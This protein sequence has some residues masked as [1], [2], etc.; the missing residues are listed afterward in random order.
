LGHQQRLNFR[1]PA[2]S[3]AGAWRRAEAMYWRLSETVTACLVADRILLLDVDRDRYLTVPR[4]LDRDFLTWLEFGTDRPETCSEILAGIGIGASDAIP[5][6]C[7]VEKPSTLD[8]RRLEAPRLTAGDLLSVGRTVMSAAREVRS[9]PFREVL[10]KRAA[11]IPRHRSATAEL[12]SRLARF[13]AART[14]IPV[15]RVCL[16]DC[17]A[18]A[19][20]AWLRRRGGD[21][22]L[23]RVRLPVF[24][25]LLAPGGRC[26]HRRPSGK[27]IALRADPSPAMSADYLA[28]AIGSREPEPAVQRLVQGLTRRGFIVHSTCGWI[29]AL[30]PRSRH[31]AGRRTRLGR[32]NAVRSRRDACSNCTAC[33]RVGAVPSPA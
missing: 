26:G 27:P 11:R 30:R 23:R 1:A 2:P 28:F 15:P 8:S 10:A 14:L 31:P 20:M 33:R 5:Q 21:P 16:H 7:F 6:R 13:R 24:G 19:C 22:G 32:R 12:E 4:T 9:R 17:L 18:F 3:G 25:A 29:F